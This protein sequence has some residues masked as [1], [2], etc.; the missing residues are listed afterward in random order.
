MAS[1]KWA[2]VPVH[3]RYKGHPVRSQRTL[4]PGDLPCVRAQCLE[5][6]SLLL[7]ILLLGLVAV[8]KAQE[9]P[10][11]DLEDVRMEG[12]MGGRRRWP[13]LLLDAEGKDVTLKVEFDSIL[14]LSSL[15]KDS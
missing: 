9:A 4:C 13:G 15:I 14:H 5:M 10:P 7:T 6:K 8:L 2:H 3:G 1:A 11:D 12:T